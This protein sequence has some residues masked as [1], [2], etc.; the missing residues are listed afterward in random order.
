MSHFTLKHWSQCSDNKFFHSCVEYCTH[1]LLLVIRYNFE[2]LL[3]KTFFMVIQIYERFLWILGV[4]TK[5]KVSDSWVFNC[6]ENT[7][8]QNYQVHILFEIFNSYISAFSNHTF[9]NHNGF[10]RT[11]FLK[12]CSWILQLMYVTDS[13]GATTLN[14]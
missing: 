7:E 10:S 6:E 2:C 5:F 14:I 13:Y 9:T 12:I 1:N 11:H 3:F 4:L 8:F